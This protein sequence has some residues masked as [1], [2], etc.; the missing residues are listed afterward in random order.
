MGL[1][2]GVVKILEMPRYIY[3]WSRYE[4]YTFSKPIIILM[5]VF[6]ENVY[7]NVEKGIEE[8]KLIH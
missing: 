5:N 1:Y 4:C 2:T 6:D 8:G 7:Q 3:N